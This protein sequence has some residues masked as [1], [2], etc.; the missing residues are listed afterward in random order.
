MSRPFAPHQ[1]SPRALILL[2]QGFEDIRVGVTALMLS[3]GQHAWQGSLRAVSGFTLLTMF[4][5]APVPTREGPAVFPEGS[6]S[7]R[8]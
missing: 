8:V 5:A 1:P 4:P 6:F 3:E 2:P 7:R